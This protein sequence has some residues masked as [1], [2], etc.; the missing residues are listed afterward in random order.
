LFLVKHLIG[1]WAQALEGEMNLK[2]FGKD[3]NRRY[4]E[5]NLDGLMRG[6]FV[7]R[8]AG[9]ANAI[10]NGVLT[11]NEGR[12]LDNRQPLPGG[13]DL[14]IQGATVPL[15]SQTKPAPANPPPDPQARAFDAMGESFRVMAEAQKLEASKP[16]VNVTIRNDVENLRLDPSSIPAPIVNVAP[17]E[18]HVAP[19][20]VNVSPPV[21]NYTPPPEKKGKRTR[22]TVLKHDAK[23]RIK[24]FEQE[25]VTD[26]D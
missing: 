5:H 19:P 17:P 11:P 10:Q 23:G 22:T 14:L 6:D 3:N 15:G 16:P 7:S 20:V 12:A 1:Q 9:M 8:M 2:L 4:V 18:V 13:D 26:G 25:E 24:E 21:V